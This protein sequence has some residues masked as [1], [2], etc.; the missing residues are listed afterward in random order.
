VKIHSALV[1]FR[2]EMNWRR[3]STACHNNVLF[4]CSVCQKGLKLQLIY[5][6]KDYRRFANNTCPCLNRVKNCNA[7]NIPQKLKRPFLLSIEIHPGIIKQLSLGTEIGND[8]HSTTGTLCTTWN[9][10]VNI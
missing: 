1:E 8:W 10:F 2:S 9:Y 6:I 5:I 7:G 4:S 3:T